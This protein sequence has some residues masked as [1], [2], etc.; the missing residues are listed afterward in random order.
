MKIR[1]RRGKLRRQNFKEEKK[2]L[3]KREKKNKKI[4]LINGHRIDYPDET[5]FINRL[6]FTFRVAGPHL[7]SPL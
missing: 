4:N 2:S 7:I 5:F 6:I 3:E 1:G